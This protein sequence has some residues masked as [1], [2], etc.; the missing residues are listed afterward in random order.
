MK[1]MLSLSAHLPEVT[2]A[3]GDTV[4][5]EG[6]QAG[7]MWILVS[8]AMHV[9]KGEVVVNIIAEPGAVIGEISLL[10]NAN[11]GATVRAAEPTVL[12][13]AEDGM[14]LLQSDPAITTFIA[15]GL[16]QRLNL[17]TTYL[18]DLQHQYG[19]APGLS[20]IPE[21]LRRLTSRQRPAARTGSVRD[22]NPDY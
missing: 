15:T 21:V 16:A 5:E 19:D 8:G 2:F 1:D 14:A 20:I 22:P 3:P 17:V 11:Y 10:L 13:F 7:A 4:I 12:R 9:Y 6:G 18:V